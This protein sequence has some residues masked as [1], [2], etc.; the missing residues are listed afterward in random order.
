MKRLLLNQMLS[1]SQS[2]KLLL[3]AIFIILLNSFAH[4]QHTVSGKVTDKIGEPLIGANILLQ[5]TAK[6]TVTDVDGTYTIRLAEDEKNGVLLISYTGFTPRKIDIANRTVIDIVLEQGSFLDE[7]VVTGVFDER[8]RMESSIAISVLR[9][10]KLREVVPL[11]AADLLKN[12]PGV[13]VNSSLGEIRNTVYSRGVSVGSNDGASGFFYVSM[14]EDGLP[15]TNA[16]FTNYGPDYFLRT[17]ATL[18][19]LEAVRGGTASILGNNAPGGIFNYVSK[20][21]GD[22]LAGEF[23]TRLGLEGDGRN[24]YYR[25]DI[26]IGGPLSKDKT[27]TYNIGGFLRQSDGARYPGYPMN[28]GGQV[29]ANIAK[30]LGD[31]KGAVKL[32]VKYLNDRNAWFEFLP[33]IG[34]DNPRLPEGF[35]QTNSVLI[36]ATQTTFTMNQTG[37]TKSYDSRDKVHSTDISVG[38]NFDYNLGNGWSIDNKMRYSDKASIWNTTAIAY[39]FDVSGLIWYAVNGQLGSFGTYSFR[40]LSSSTELANI[41]Q[42]PVIIDG[43]FTGFDFIVNKDMLPGASAQPTSLL[44]NPLFFTE[45][46]MSEFIDQ[47]TISKKLDNMKFTAG[48]FYANSQLDRLFSFGVGSMHTQLKSPRPTPTSILYTDFD[49]QTF[50]VTNPDGIIGGSGRSAP[51]NINTVTQNQLALF[52]GHN[53]EI[54]RNL[55]FDWGVRYETIAING[56]NQIAADRSTAS[57]GGTDGNPATLYDNTEGAITGTYRFDETVSTL[58]FSGGLNYKFSDNFAL[59]GRYSQGRKAPDMQLFI[60]VATDATE[61]LLDPIPQN[62]QQIELGL[63]AKTGNLNLF[64]TPFYSILSNVPIQQIGQETEDI[65]SFYLTP[66]LFNKY[67]TGGVEIEG[68]Y[69]FTPQFNIRAVATFQ[70]STAV[71]FS[72]WN[73]GEVGSADDTVADFSGNETDNNARA[74]LRLTP[75][76]NSGKFYASL[77]WSYMGKRAANVPNAFQLP[78]FHQTDLNMGY[79]FTKKLQVQANVTNIFNSVGIMG[80]SAPG[81]FPAALDRQGF[82]RA[83]LE[84][85]PNAVYSSLSIPPRA[86]FLTFSY[87]F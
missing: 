13:F 39:P 72:S 78:A 53:W 26:N 34:F 62:I 41:T 29:K 74:M 6:G 64:F 54:T 50:Q 65:T 61:Q 52:F 58:S 48:L 11:S 42:A 77:D 24:P 68:V 75:A 81:G 28:N 7:V 70:A 33:T 16:T 12:V 10:E 73:L 44:F 36:P 57:P 31:G 45:N 25:A 32:Y 19:R 17:D 23:R 55:N 8:S 59:Y 22:T 71:Q 84:A 85:N 18:G 4:A 87:F 76:Y 27:L 60:D 35:E 1:L 37:E 86:Y 51:V 83:S 66:T 14:Q 30:F 82:T 15:V 80:W 40:D 47:F 46:K 43:N 3:P 20:T 56:N 63:K 69:N 67:E 49:G 21:G 2:K 38:L 79:N 5:N 9:E